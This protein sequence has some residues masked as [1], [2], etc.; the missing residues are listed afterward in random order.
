[1][2]PQKYLFTIQVMPG[3]NGVEA[4]RAIRELDPIVDQK[5]RVI[6]F[7]LTGNALSEDV[8]EFIEAGCDEVFVPSRQENYTYT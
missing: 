2:H 8:S 5:R 3:M 7:G 4:V 6:I 1:M